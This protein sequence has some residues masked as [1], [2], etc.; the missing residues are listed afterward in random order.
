MYD[1]NGPAGQAAEA[2]EKGTA[3]WDAIN[4]ALAA[5]YPGQEPQHFGAV[6]PWTLGGDNPLDGISVYWN[7]Q[8]RPHW[9]YVTYGISELFGKQSDDP[10]VSGFGFEMTF[11]LL[12]PAGARAADVP[13]AWPMNLLQNL[14][15]YVF[16]SGNVFE[17]GHHMNANGPIALDHDTLLRHVAF[18]DDPQLPPRVTANGRVAFLQV[19]G[20]ADGEMAA[21]LRWSTDAVLAVLEPAM[22]RWITDLDRSDLLDDPGLAAQVDAGSRRDGSST[23]LLFAETLDWHAA[24]QGGAVEL[25]LGAGQVPGL[26]QL[27]PARLPFGKPLELYGRERRWTFEAG[28]ADAVQVEGEAARCTLSAATLDTLL[29]RLEPRCGLYPLGDGD[30]LALRVEPTRMRDG[31]D[32]PLG[33]VG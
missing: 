19:V 14:A 30:V 3:G 12:A 21:I 4:A 31:K 15:R 23:A 10:E 26:L 9:H 32:T 28:T 7:E 6:L 13:P 22:P 2:D 1:D 11:R 16:E 5:L 33:T 17:P 8:P 18:V 27:L 25:I 20:L 24:G 29:A